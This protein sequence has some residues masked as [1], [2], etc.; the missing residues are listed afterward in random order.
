MSVGE[1]QGHRSISDISLIKTHPFAPVYSEAAL[2]A[3]ALKN[4]S[5]RSYNCF[6][7]AL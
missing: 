1:T 2:Q 4:V 7:A 5:R 3:Q 6:M